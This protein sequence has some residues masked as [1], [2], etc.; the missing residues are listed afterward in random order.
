MI[1]LSLP[2]DGVGDGDGDGDGERTSTEI[3]GF[4]E[5][6]SQSCEFLLTKHE[7]RV[8]GDALLYPNIAVCWC[9]SCESVEVETGATVIQC[10]SITGDNNY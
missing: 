7:R 2:G 3:W 4:G 5:S 8:D 6:E 10:V 9:P 1:D